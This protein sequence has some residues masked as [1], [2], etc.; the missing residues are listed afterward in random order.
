MASSRT[1]STAQLVVP[2]THDDFVALS[3]IA[4]QR[5]DDSIIAAA[6]DAIRAYVAAQA[7]P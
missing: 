6:T 4:H 2:V 5:P 1:K 3:A 7:Q